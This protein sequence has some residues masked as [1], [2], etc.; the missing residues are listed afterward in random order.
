M[1][2]KINFRNLFRTMLCI[3]IPPTT[4]TAPNSDETD[5]PPPI[6]TVHSLNYSQRKSLNSRSFLLQNKT[7]IFLTPN[8]WNQIDFPVTLVTSLP[9]K[10][11]ALCDTRTLYL[12]GLSQR[13]IVNNTNDTY[14]TIWL[15]NDSK[16]S[17][18]LVPFELMIHC[19]LILQERRYI[20]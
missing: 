14:L 1:L 9:A 8:S 2:K 16:S 11:I 20:D 12:R 13:P 19:H 7:A 17:V 18:E 5:G 3:T 10:C 6:L 15:H 4:S